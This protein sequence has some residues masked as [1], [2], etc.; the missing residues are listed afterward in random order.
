[1]KSK[2]N[3][4][5]RSIRRFLQLDTWG[6]DI[7]RIK[8]RLTEMMLNQELEVARGDAFEHDLND[9]ESRVEKLERIVALDGKSLSVILEVLEV[10]TRPSEEP[11]PETP[12]VHHRR[13]RLPLNGDDAHQGG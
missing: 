10:M 4:V 1:M 9:L 3:V 8:R 2:T 6:Q 5:V 12:A 7:F 11:E 13:R